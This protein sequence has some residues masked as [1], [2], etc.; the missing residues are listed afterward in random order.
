[1]IDRER[2]LLERIATLEKQVKALLAHINDL[3]DPV[4]LEP[5]QEPSRS[6]RP[7]SCALGGPLDGLELWIWPDGSAQLRTTVSRV[8]LHCENHSSI[9]VSQLRYDSV[10]EDLTWTPGQP[11]TKTHLKV[12]REAL[13]LD[14]VT[15]GRDLQ[16][17]LEKR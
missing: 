14:G 1:M 17:L 16:A 5:E 15:P 6:R 10:A 3:A 8:L 4:D 9:L 7:R 12:L 11:T 2:V 13:T